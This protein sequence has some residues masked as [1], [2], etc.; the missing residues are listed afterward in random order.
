MIKI[1]W[2]TVCDILKYTFFNN[3]KIVLIPILTLKKTTMT[4]MILVYMKVTTKCNH[5]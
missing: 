3:G 2:C 1:Y 4:I 5:Q